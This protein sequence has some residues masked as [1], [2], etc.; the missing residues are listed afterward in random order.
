M[1]DLYTNNPMTQ[2][3]DQARSVFGD[4]PAD[5]ARGVASNMTN[6]P[7]FQ[8]PLQGQKTA[9]SAMDEIAAY[10][11]QLASQFQQGNQQAMQATQQNNQ[12]LSNFASAGA[13]PQETIAKG[14]QNIPQTQYQTYNG[15]LSPFVSSG[16]ASGQQQA[17]TDTFNMATQ[18][19][20]ALE[21]TIGTEAQAYA[22]ALRYALAQEELKVE[23]ER[24]EQERLDQIEQQKWNREYELLSLTGGTIY[25]PWDGKTYTIPVPE[26]AKSGTFDINS[27]LQSMR[28]QN[29]QIQGSG[30]NSNYAINPY[31]AMQSRP[32]L[33]S[34]EK[35]PESSSFSVNPKNISKYMFPFLPQVGSVM[36]K[37][38]D[39]TKKYTK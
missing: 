8:E 15:I 7:T 20:S 10:D 38:D 14:Q 22:E 19:R 33:E 26:S 29:P 23:Q 25:N 18:T 31:N 17:A 28:T 39:W 34:F 6:S 1:P 24:A 37:V 21:K 13:T 4:N 3:L 9:L 12:M 5:V 27:A 32:P 2:R 36:N 35:E 30:T 16:L 11:K